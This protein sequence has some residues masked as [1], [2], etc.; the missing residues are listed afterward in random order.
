MNEPALQL[1]E[2]ARRGDEQAAARLIELFYQRL[3]AFLRRLAGN[4]ADAADL[5][6]RAFARIWPALP[7]FA[8]RSSV[9][10]WMHSIAYRTYVD[11]LRANHRTEDRSDEWWAQRAAGGRTPD[12]AA[13][14]ADL[15][16]SLYAAVDHLE[17]D[18]RATVHLHYY[19][20]LTL[21][22]TADTLGVATSTVKYRL[23]QAIAVLQAEFKE[24]PALQPSS[25]RCL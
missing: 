5:T 4:D 18:V 11:W 19:Q 24:E 6:Q 14:A 17:P 25:P 13:V 2:T 7:G 8:G 16:A 22:E 15:A 21:D 23:R 12:E 20:G 10:S 1:V 3:Y 9:A